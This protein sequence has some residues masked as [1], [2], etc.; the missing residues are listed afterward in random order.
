MISEQLSKICV[1]EEKLVRANS[2]VISLKAKRFLMEKGIDFT[3]LDNLIM[4]KGE[5]SAT[6]EEILDE[7]IKLAGL[8]KGDPTTQRPTPQE[9]AKAKADREAELKK[10][11]KKEEEEAVEDVDKPKRKRR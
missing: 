5:V 10:E 2:N 3:D 4:A 9:I 11:A 8:V 6:E 1:N 7:Y